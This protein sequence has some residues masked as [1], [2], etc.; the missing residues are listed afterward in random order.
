MPPRLRLVA[1]RLHARPGLDMRDTGLS[2]PVNTAPYPLTIR[3]PGSRP[4]R[5]AVSFQTAAV[6]SDIPSVRS[7]RQ[8]SPKT[9]AQECW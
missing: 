3:G 1:A 8:G 9:W 4:S 2:I 7:S 6:C 5:P